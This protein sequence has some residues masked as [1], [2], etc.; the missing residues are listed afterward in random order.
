VTDEQRAWA[1]KLDKMLIAADP[2]KKEGFDRLTCRLLS[3]PSTSEQTKVALI[4]LIIPYRRGLPK[5]EIEAN[6]SFSYTEA[7]QKMREKRGQ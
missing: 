7:L 5:Q 2:N 4:K 1:A 6:I 3:A